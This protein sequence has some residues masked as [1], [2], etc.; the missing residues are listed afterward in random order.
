MELMNLLQWPAM[1]VT[2]AASWLVAS[3]RAGKRNW[4]FWL[5]LVSNVLWIAW[6]L[7]AGAPALIALQVCL[8]AMNIRGAMK[9][10]KAKADAE[11]SDAQVDGRRP[12]S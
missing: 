5:F 10:E 7:Y 3:T 8:A 1:A 9:T 2:I 12:T 6:G 11:R 4:G